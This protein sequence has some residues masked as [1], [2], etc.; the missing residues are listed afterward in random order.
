MLLNYSPVILGRKRR[1]N[2]MDSSN[3]ITGV[4]LIV[5]ALFIFGLIIGYCNG[6]LAQI[7][8]HKK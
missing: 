4:I 6:R 5:C 7:D 3:V 8:N 1:R 2:K